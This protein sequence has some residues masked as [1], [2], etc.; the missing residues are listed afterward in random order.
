M[1]VT[2]PDDLAQTI[3]SLMQSGGYRST[4]DVLR[5]AVQMLEKDQERREN[6]EALRKSLQESVDQIA[7]GKVHDGEE[8]FAEVLR[9]LGDDSEAA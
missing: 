3:A 5:A 9:E 8:V 4:D 6:V 1:T 2:V 7:Q